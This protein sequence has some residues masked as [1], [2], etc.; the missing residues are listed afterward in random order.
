ML[1][2]PLDVGVDAKGNVYIADSSN[3]RVR[4]VNSSGTISTL[5]GTAG[6]GYNGNGLPATSTNIFPSA[7]NV[8][9]KGVVYVTDLGSYRVRKIH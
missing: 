7:V 5:A 8:S 4:V 2:L 6:G 9:P 3:D 1:N